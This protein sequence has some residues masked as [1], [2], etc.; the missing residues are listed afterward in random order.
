MTIE[1]T[2]DPRTR[3]EITL[4]SGKVEGAYLNALKQVK[5]YNGPKGP[6][7]PDK[8]ANLVVDGTRIGLG[9]TERDSIRAK[10]V[11]G[12]YHDVV[13]GVEVSV[14]V[15]PVEVDGKTFYNAK[16][17]QV[18]I[19]DVS[20]AK[21]AD[22]IAAG[23]K[24]TYKPRD[25]TGIEVGHSINCA[26]NFLA[27]EDQDEDTLIATAKK[28]HE[29]TTALKQKTRL[30]KPDASEYDIGASVGQA[31]LASASLGVFETVE[32]VVA[33]AEFILDNVV[34][35]LHEYVVASK[36]D[37]EKKSKVEKRSAPK[38]VAKPKAKPQ[39]KAKPPVED[40]PEDDLDD[41]VP[42]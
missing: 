17:S 41:E 21:T 31:V 13:E 24:T 7:T 4:V 2:T 5:T 18:L 12:N 8:S 37:T 10:D 32:E 19:L 11:D 22:E 36:E 20:G 15:D 39:R 35:P 38:P 34:D 40:F 30:N 23:K 29:A 1:T 27:S 42:F 26:M 9:L 25:T 6:W 28:F 33:N 3:K 16:T 14:E